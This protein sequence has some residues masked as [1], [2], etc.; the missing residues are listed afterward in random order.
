MAYLLDVAY[1]YMAF[2][3]G[4]QKIHGQKKK[5]KKIH[6]QVAVADL[7]SVFWPPNLFNATLKQVFKFSRIYLSLDSSV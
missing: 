4:C 1:C 5:K 2:A 7:N 6:G 3:Q